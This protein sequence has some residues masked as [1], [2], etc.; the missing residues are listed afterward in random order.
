MK[1]AQ[2]IIRNMQEC[3]VD[4]IFAI[5]QACFSKP[6]TRQA[7][8]EVVTDEKAFY[9][10]AVDSQMKKA[11]GYVGAYLILDEADI[12]QVAIASSYRR[13]GIASALLQDFMQKL[14]AKE[15]RA[16]T[17]EV[18]ASNRAAIS[19]YEKMGFQTEGIRKN[20]YEAP[21]EDA[22]IMWKR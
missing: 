18:R 20:F 16:I 17:L 13:K 22:C 4:D 12:N 9:L 19:L 7:L 21:I 10:V 15:I 8:L 1:D 5:E 6:W 3:D 14:S 2:I 11:V